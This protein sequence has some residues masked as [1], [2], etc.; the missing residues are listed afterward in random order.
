MERSIETLNNDNEFDVLLEDCFEMYEDEYFKDCFELQYPVNVVFPD[1][2]TQI[3][4]SDDD[5]DIIEDTFYEENVNEEEYLSFVYPVTIIWEDGTEEMINN[6]DDLE[7]AFETCDEHDCDDK[8]RGDRGGHH[9]EGGRDKERCFEVIFP[10]TIVL[11]DGT[12]ET[13][14]SRRDLRELVKDLDE[15]ENEEEGEDGQEEDEDNKPFSIVFPIEVML[16][17]DSTTSI[18][19]EEAFEILKESCDD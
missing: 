11:K 16:E 13:V 17:D 8:D 19:S 14:S 15:D 12:E 10:I 5:L 6:D 2:T 1:G 4:N 9:N 3:A 7:V 18:D